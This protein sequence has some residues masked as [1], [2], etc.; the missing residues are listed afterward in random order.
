M[1][2]R[3]MRL[4]AIHRAVLEGDLNRVNRLITVNRACLDAQ[5]ASG[6]TPLMLA[7]LYGH[8]RIVIALIGKRAQVDIKDNKG[9]IAANYAERGS[10]ATS[11]FRRY[12]A[13]FRPLATPQVFQRNR[14]EI[15]KFLSDASAFRRINQD[16]VPSLPMLY[17]EHN[18]L[19]VLKPI[20]LVKYK[21]DLTRTTVAYI[22]SGR[23]VKPQMCAVSG[24]S[25]HDNHIPG[26]LENATYTRLVKE[27]CAFLGFRLQRFWRD[28][29]EDG[30]WH[31]CH[32]EK[33]LTMYWVM[34]Q[35][36]Y[37]FGSDDPTRMRDLKGLNLPDDRKVASIYLDHLPCMDCVLFVH[38]IYKA[39]GIDIVLFTRPF[40]QL[41]SRKA[42]NGYC[43]NCSCK[44]CRARQQEKGQDKKEKRL[45]QPLPNA[46]KIAVP[47]NDRASSNGF[48]H[49]LGGSEDEGRSNYAQD[50]E[51][52]LGA[53]TGSCGEDNAIAAVPTTCCEGAGASADRRPLPKATPGYWVMHDGYWLDSNY[54]N[55][56]PGGPVEHLDPTKPQA[57]PLG[58]EY[59]FGRHRQPS[60]VDQSPAFGSPGPASQLAQQG[61]R[62]SPYSQR[63]PSSYPDPVSY[64]DG[65]SGYFDSIEVAPRRATPRLFGRRT[66]RAPRTPSVRELSVA[67]GSLYSPSIHHARTSRPKR[68]L[69]DT[70]ANLRLQDRYAYKEP[71]QRQK[72]K[73]KPKPKPRSQ[74]APEPEPQQQPP[75]PNRQSASPAPPKAKPAA[76]PKPATKAA[77]TRKPAKAA[78]R[79]T[80]TATA[81]AAGAGTGTKPPRPKKR[82]SRRRA[83][84]ASSREGVIAANSTLVANIRYRRLRKE[85]QRAASASAPPPPPPAVVRR[86]SA[87]GFARGEEDEVGVV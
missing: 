61:F 9:K 23:G 25:P 26:V 46:P 12:K 71:K 74:P 83:A 1:A 56:L 77:S 34:K 11:L 45:Q 82:Q 48:L 66:S 21:Q 55:P 62:P 54:R 37:A 85:A 50:D 7:S 64:Q 19:I 87:G 5:N 60:L 13:H 30:L 24:W 31:A 43:S 18:R 72:Q 78:P 59:R 4:A 27:A 73:Q 41:G 32:C 15:F 39:T 76:P 17:K 47:D 53:D 63:E 69:R 33:K 16:R 8:V 35:I 75:P 28:N 79:K 49:E 81:A 80:K 84:A 40:V 42:I 51:Q 52:G 36:R 6:S 70:I 14:E 65:H 68:V 22:S 67:S 3:H 86:R 44:E 10:F 57:R 29:G 38:E 20:G 58:Q 2:S